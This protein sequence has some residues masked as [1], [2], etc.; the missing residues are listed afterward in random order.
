MAG[1]KVTRAARRDL[2]EIGRFT[3]ERWGAEQADR[4]LAQLDECF[5]L[6][7]RAPTSGRICDEIKDGYRRYRHGR[8]V[9]FYRIARAQVHVIRILHEQ[10]LPQRHL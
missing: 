8:H 2:L 4:Y 7:A 3:V 6:L 1:L 9:I 5:R 10:M